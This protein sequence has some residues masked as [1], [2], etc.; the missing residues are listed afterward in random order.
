MKPSKLVVEFD[1]LDDINNIQWIA[2]RSY[3]AVA[4][5][6]HKFRPI[7]RMFGAEYLVT[8]I[9]HEPG[10]QPDLTSERLID[11]FSYQQ[12]LTVTLERLPS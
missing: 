3:N 7:I 6:W 8:E 2:T 9:A 12:K 1:C 10:H 4:P 11:L 5:D